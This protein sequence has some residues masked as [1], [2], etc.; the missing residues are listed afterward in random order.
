MSE[1]LNRGTGL[2]LIEVVN[3]NPNGDPD[4]ENDPRIR[5]DGHG[6]ISPVSF[7][8]KLRDL[9]DEDGP[10]WEKFGAGLDK[11]KY[12]IL[13]KR[14]TQ[15]SA[16]ANKAQKS[17]F[18]DKHWDARLFGNTILQESKDMPIQTGVAQFGLGVSVSPIFIERLTTTRVT[19][20]QDAKSKGMAPLS[21]RVVQHG[22][23][24][25]PFF[26]N[27]TMA[28][29]TKCTQEDINLLL[30]L[31]PYAYS[32][33]ASYLRPQVNIR[34]AFYIE[35]DSPIGK[36]N[37]FEV[38]ERL[39]PKRVHDDGKPSASWSDYDAEALMGQFD[40]IKQDYKEKTKA[41]RDLVQEMGI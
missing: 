37:D 7:K 9:V 23:Y 15:H 34:H 22:V 26:I 1:F 13:E 30:R 32:Q 4:R 10:V 33:T 6:E 20:V 17:D 39:T 31:I 28:V 16:L 36:F 41:V 12:E 14:G 19:P 27:A 40:Q 21:F 24:C 38:I 5:P 35:H 3:S 11:K 29:K 25:M 2:I 8:R 18:L